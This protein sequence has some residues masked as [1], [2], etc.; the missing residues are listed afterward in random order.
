MAVTR[1]VLPRKGIIQPR[2]GD[3]Y[4]TDLDANWSTIDSLLQD[5]D[6]VA[7]FNCI[8]YAVKFAGADAGAKVAAAIADLPAT[9]GTVDACGLEGAQTWS[10]DPFAG[11]TKPLTLILGTATITVNASVT[12]PA[13]T[14]IE[15]SQGSVLAIAT[16]VTV[17]WQGGLR[18]PLAQI[19]SLTGTGKVVFSGARPSTGAVYPQWFGAKGDGTTDDAAAIQA[20]LYAAG[21]GN[22]VYVNNPGVV[23]LPAGVY[24]IGTTLIVPGDCRLASAGHSNPNFSPGGASWPGAM[25]KVKAGSN[26]DAIHAG[27]VGVASSYWHYGQIEN[28]HI[29]AAP[30]QTSGN[31]IVIQSMGE[32]AHLQ[33]VQVDYFPESGIKFQGDQ[34]PFRIREIAVFGNGVGVEFVGASTGETFGQVAGSIEIWGLSGDDNGKMLW[35]HQLDSGASIGWASAINIY[36]IKTETVNDKHNPLVEIS[37]FSGGLVQFIGG[38]ISD[39]SASKTANKAVVHID[40]TAPAQVSFLGTGIEGYPRLIQDDYRSVIVPGEGPYG[41]ARKFVTYG[42]GADWLMSEPVVMG[43][44][45][46]DPTQ[47]HLQVSGETWL[48]RL[49]LSKGTAVVNGDFALSAGWG[50]GATVAAQFGTD[51]GGYIQV[52]PGTGP[53]A[54][55]TITL[56]FHDGQWGVISGTTHPPTCFAAASDGT[57]VYPSTVYS[58]SVTFTYKGMP[59]GPVYI[60]W[61]CVGMP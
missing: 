23:L 8:R 39:Y 35:I 12:V 7:E 36:G 57:P 58:T 27:S 31:G 52:T 13:D 20:A 16:G 5:A 51:A 6:D 30:G 41:Y 28:L 34:A 48:K 22:G 55:P 53:S 56:T 42:V 44:S 29:L 59:S 46:L 3:N 19:F 26:I 24:I 14:H 45:D 38:R 17:T 49:Y 10:S 32:N 1:T 21:P 60:N 40:N 37:R 50:S 2:H 9:G 25:I 15:F 11:A 43:P 47:A 18:A 4:E 54:N 33:N 61:L